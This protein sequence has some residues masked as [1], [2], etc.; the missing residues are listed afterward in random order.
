MWALIHMAFRISKPFNV[1]NLF[2]TW[3]SGFGRN[4]RKIILLGVATIYWSLWLNRNYIIFEKNPSTLQVI[5]TNAHWLRTWVILQKCGVATYGCGGYIIL[6]VSGQGLFLV[7]MGGC[8]VF[9]LITIRVC[10]LSTL[11]VLKLCGFLSSLEEI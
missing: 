8:L 7:H 1:S 10:G 11:F 4:I 9:G 5:H 2:G 6:G 3:F